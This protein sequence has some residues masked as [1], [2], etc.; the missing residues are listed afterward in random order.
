MRAVRARVC[1]RARVGARATGATRRATRGWDDVGVGMTP[2]ASTRRTTGA[3]TRARGRTRG[4]TARPRSSTVPAPEGA[5]VTV[6][7][8]AVAMK[9]WFAR[10]TEAPWDATAA[11]WREFFALKSIGAVVEVDNDRAT[12]SATEVESHGLNFP[13]CK[14][15]ALARAKAN[16]VRFRQNY[17]VMAAA[18]ALIGCECA[19]F[20]LALT[21]FY[22]HLAATS[23]KIL[24]ELELGTRGALKWNAE[25]VAGVPRKRLRRVTL[26]SAIV[27]FLLSDAT[28]NTYAVVRSVMWTSVVAV[29][30][31]MLRPIDLKGTLANIV[32]EFRAAKSKEELKD[33]AQAGFNSMK[34][35]IGE[36]VKPEN[37]K[38]VFVVEK[39]ARKTSSTGNEEEEQAKREN[40]DGAIDVDAKNVEENKYLP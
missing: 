9:K 40:P 25:V 21:L 38:P 2:T 30:H 22:V 18:A 39:G 29:F 24:G 31:A 35:W 6:A 28:A 12:V 1:A 33:A 17:L 20:G 7:F 13:S 8:D 32:K 26:A 14:A 16:T 23:D 10:A 4:W 37:A 15:E 19:A 11:T 34:A 3:V 27:L 36:K 5:E